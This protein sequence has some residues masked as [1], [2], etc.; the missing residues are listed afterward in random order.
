MNAQGRAKGNMNFLSGN[1]TRSKH[2]PTSTVGRGRAV[3]EIAASDIDV[4]TWSDE[5]ISVQLGDSLE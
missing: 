2:T 1:S 4:T 3:K 5:L